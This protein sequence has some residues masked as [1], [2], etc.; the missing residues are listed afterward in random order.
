MPLSSSNE[1][2][3]IPPFTRTSVPLSCTFL[4][5]LTDN[6]DRVAI[7]SRKTA[8]ASLL[9]F[10][11]NVLVTISGTS[12]NSGVNFGPSYSTIN[13]TLQI[14][15]FGYVN[16]Y[17]PTYATNSLLQYNTAGSYLRFNEWNNTVGNPGY[18]YNVQVSN[19]GTRFIPAGTANAYAGTTL[20]M[21]GTLTIDAGCFFDMTNTNTNNMTVPLN[22]GSGILIN[23]SLVESQSAGGDVS[24]GGTWTNNGTFT[25]YS[26]KVTFSGIAAQ[27]ITG[28]NKSCT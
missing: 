28:S 1:L 5:S 10:S 9:S 24:L 17:P 18:P 6:A 20:N 2:P 26:R 11:S 4:L 12:A 27:S 8:L 15:A 13:G 7:I 3:P 21:A 25:P 16:T 19:P 23:G 22:V 14:N